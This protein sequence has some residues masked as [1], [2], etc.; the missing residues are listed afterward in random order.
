MSSLT[1][2]KHSIL[3]LPFS[4]VAIDFLFRLSSSFLKTYPSH[5]NLSDLIIQLFNVF[6]AMKIII[7]YTDLVEADYVNILL[8]LPIIPIC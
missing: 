3:G 2:C 8:G 5:A 4:P 7:L 6:T 1:S